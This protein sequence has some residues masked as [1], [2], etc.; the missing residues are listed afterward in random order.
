[1]YAYVHKYI[2]KSMCVYVYKRVSVKT[3]DRY[4]KFDF[5]L[6]D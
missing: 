5:R 3:R 2:Q 4:E 6:N 1:M